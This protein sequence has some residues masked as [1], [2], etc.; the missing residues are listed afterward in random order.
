MLQQL[1]DHDYNQFFNAELF[2]TQDG[3][4][5]HIKLSKGLRDLLKKKRDFPT[6]VQIK[7]SSL[8]AACL[9]T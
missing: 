5:K 1:I 3:V 7:V 6:W 4:N 9:S 8:G 2:V